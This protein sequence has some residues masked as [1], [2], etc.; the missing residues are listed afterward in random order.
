MPGGVFRP[1]S[2]KRPKRYGYAAM[3]VP[4]HFLV[5]PRADKYQK[6]YDDG[7]RAM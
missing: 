1:H 2:P 6:C 5:G 7:A 4:D 3:R